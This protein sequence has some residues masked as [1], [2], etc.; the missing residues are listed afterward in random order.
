M[1][2]NNGSL[3]AGLKG[4]AEISVGQ[5]HTAVSMGSG[6]LPVLATPA[7]AA[8]MEAAA[9]AAVDGALPDGQQSV[10]VH[11]DIHHYGATP[12]GMRVVATAELVAVDG[13]NL[14]FRIAVHDEKELIGEGSHR[15]A[16]SSVAS[17]NRL[18]QQKLRRQ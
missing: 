3:Q 14:D 2:N 10:G 9:Q 13:R 7:M 11:L 4:N 16:V 17:F 12:V 6:R 18:L 15:R 1:K 5:Q 8:L